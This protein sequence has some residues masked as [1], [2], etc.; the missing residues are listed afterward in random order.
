[1]AHN[2]FSTENKKKQFFY[3]VLAGE[4]GYSHP[5][6]GLEAL[7]ILFAHYTQND[8]ESSTEASPPHTE[9]DYDYSD[10][11][12]I[13]PENSTETSHDY[14]YVGLDIGKVEFAAVPEICKG[15]ET[16]QSDGSCLRIVDAPKP[17]SA[18]DFFRLL[19]GER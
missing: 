19:Y 10:L 12:T 11:T 5:R 7:E 15:G 16:R 3:Y 14:E 13:A 6:I 4:C 2:Y 17:T 1:M 18:L 8:L 9:Y